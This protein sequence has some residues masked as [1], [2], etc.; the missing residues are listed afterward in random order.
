MD[1]KAKPP[2][3]FRVVQVL[4]LLVWVIA[5]GV[6]MRFDSLRPRV[7]RPEL[8]QIYEIDTHGHVVYITLEDALLVYG[9]IAVG[10]TGIFGS[11]IYAFRS[12]KVQT[13]RMQDGV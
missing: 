5:A 4:S 8:G 6:W 7:P 1:G 3:A 10:I 13:A 9:L 12:S 11:L 2:R